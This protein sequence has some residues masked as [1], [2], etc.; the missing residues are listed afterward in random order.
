MQTEIMKEYKF[1]QVEPIMIYSSFQQNNFILFLHPISAS[2]TLMIVAEL[3][4]KAIDL[5]IAW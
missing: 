4:K 5:A 1:Y 2:D 3:K